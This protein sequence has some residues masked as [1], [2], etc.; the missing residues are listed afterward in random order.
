MRGTIS[1]VCALLC[2]FA[3]SVLAESMAI[4][5]A[6]VHPVTAEP[7]VGNVVVDGG[8]IVAAGPNAAIPDGATRIDGAGLHVY[9]GLMDAAGQLGLIEIGAV[10]ATDDREEMGAYNAHLEA[11]TAIHPSSELIPVAR[12]NGITHAMVGPSGGRDTVIPGRA[13]L[14]NLDGWTV[15][16]MAVQRSAAMIVSWPEIVTRRFDFATFTMKESAF[17]DAKEEAD[18]KIDELRDWMDAARHYRM[19]ASVEHPRAVRD[20]QL[21]HLSTCLDHG[22]RVVVE[23]NGKRDLEAAMKFADEQGLDII[24]AG[25]RDAWKIAD[26]LAEKQIPVILGSTQSLPREDDDPYDTPY[27]APAVLVEAGVKI[28]FGSMGGAHSVR[29]LPYEA[30]QAVAFGLDPEAALKALTI[31]PAEMFGVDDRL[32]SIEVGKNANLIVTDG[33]PLLVRTQV[34][35]L[36]IDGRE[37]STDNRHR[38]L[39]EKYRARPMGR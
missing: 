14:V 16:E 3:G 24:L 13:T 25:A 4:V 26:E 5:G 12:A 21:A 6:T 23:A 39:Y 29:L 15:E 35:H 17:N 37:V 32:G 19:A 30:D 8:V 7:F 38:E 2:V 10:A 34:H 9:P 31:W 36:I 33:D 18:K 1:I 11:A 27:H 20:L 28:A 22:M